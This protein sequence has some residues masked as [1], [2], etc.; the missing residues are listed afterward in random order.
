MGISIFK[1]GNTVKNSACFAKD[2]KESP[3]SFL[4]PNLA[5]GYTV[6]SCSMPIIIFG[7]NLEII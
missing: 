7:N 2:S 4:Q 6:Y 1:F 5:Y 3:S